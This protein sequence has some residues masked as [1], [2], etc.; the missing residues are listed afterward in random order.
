[1]NRFSPWLLLLLLSPTMLCCEAFAES[2]ELATDPLDQG[3][4][5]LAESLGSRMAAREVRKLAVIEFSDLAGFE[6][7]LG[8][9]LA[10]ELTT[11]L[12]ESETGSFDIVER[13]QL[14]KV[15]KEQSLTA[16]ALFDSET[17]ADVGEILGIQGIISGS[18]ADLGSSIKINARCISVET[19]LVFAAASARI[20]K[21]GVIDHLLRQGAAPTIASQGSPGGP[22]VQASDVFFQNSFLRLTVASLGI[23]DDKRILTLALNLENLTTRPLHL[24]LEGGRSRDQNLQMVD[25]QGMA[26]SIYNN[27]IFG[28]DIQRFKGSEDNKLTT[29]S[30]K[31]RSTI[32]IEFRPRKPVRGNTFSLSMVLLHKENGRVT[33]F[34]AGLSNIRPSRPIQ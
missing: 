20:P 30:A 16:S 7:A 23:S 8:L 28:I 15:L 34:S 6:S 4:K 9:F 22:R 1:M 11:L 33:P 32:T 29:F 14:S 19:A 13:Q 2:A 31:G 17:I 24:A 3:L 5:E 21:E 27:N 10:E 18:I 12:L 25:E 26:F